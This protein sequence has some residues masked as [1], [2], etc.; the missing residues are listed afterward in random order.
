MK[1][2]IVIRANDETFE[3]Y[4]DTQKKTVACENWQTAEIVAIEMLQRYIWQLRVKKRRGE[5][6]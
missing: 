4:D 6:E 3:V 2:I 5:A 1:D